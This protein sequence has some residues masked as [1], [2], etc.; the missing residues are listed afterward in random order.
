MKQVLSAAAPTTEML[1]SEY[2]RMAEVEARM[3]WYTSLHADLLA[4]IR[5]HFGE[6]RDIRILDAGCGTGGLLRLLRQHGYHNTLGVD[7]SDIAVARTREQGFEVLQGSIADARLLAGIGKVDLLLSLDVVCSLPDEAA[8]L[9]FF[10]EAE[11]LL[12]DGGLMLVQTPAFACLGGI[13]DLAVGVNVRYTQASMRRLLEQA[14]ITGFRQRYRLVLLSPL[15]WLLRT[16]QRRR[17]KAGGELRLESDVK[18]PPRSLNALLY[19]LQ[20]TEDRL[21]PF[22]PFGCSLQILINK[23]QRWP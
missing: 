19:F 14:G 21:L 6:R 9:S 7:I 5:R 8:R 23:G 1:A 15:I 17:L 20:R 16:L 12:D 13:H 22:R 2:R 10:Q 3:W 4:L 18:M 11:R